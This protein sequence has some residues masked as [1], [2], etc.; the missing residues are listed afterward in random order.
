MSFKAPTLF[1]LALLPIA[2]CS[3]NPPPVASAPPPRPA[4]ASA[5]Q[6]FINMAAAGDAAEIQGAQLA[7]SKAHRSAVKKYAAQMIS[8]HTATTQQLTTIAQSKGVTPVAAPSEGAQDTMAKLQADRGAAFD[9]AY[10]R[11]Q[12][13]DHQNMVQAYQDEIANGQDADVKAFAQQTLP[14]VEKHLHEA[15]ALSG[16]RG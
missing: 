7:Q 14:A 10:V 6:M 8:D 11:D 9:R 16:H 4:L 5:D 2:A 3:S 13:M 15:Q 12:V 1:A